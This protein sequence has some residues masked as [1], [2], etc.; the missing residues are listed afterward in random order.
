MNIKKQIILDDKDYERLVHDANLS[1]DEIKSEIASA[2]TTDMVFSFDF[3]VNKKV[4]G[5]TR[6]ESATHNLGYNEYD[7]VIIYQFTPPYHQLKDLMRRRY[8]SAYNKSKEM[9][10]DISSMTYLPCPDAFN[11]INIE[12]MHVILDRVNKIIDENKDK[13][14]NPTR[15]TCVH[16]HDR[17]W[18]KRYGKV[19]CSIWQVC[20][21]YI[22]PNRKYD[23]EQKTYT[24]RPSDKACPNYEYGDDNFENRKRCLKKKNT[25]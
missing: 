4:T 7:K 17:E 2:L 5:N 15:A 12:K 22:N 1:N 20:D 25:R 13:L 14:K 6:I 24:G 18:A 16:L 19:C 3:D 21:H 8:E 9:D 10:I 11:V 23:R